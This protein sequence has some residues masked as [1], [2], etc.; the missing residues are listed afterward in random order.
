LARSIDE[1][2]RQVERQFVGNVMVFRNPSIIRAAFGVLF[3][4]TD[5]WGVNCLPKV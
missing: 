2:L 4:N 5:D 1:Y 3:E